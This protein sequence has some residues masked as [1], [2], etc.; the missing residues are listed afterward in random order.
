MEYVLQVLLVLG[1]VLLLWAGL[2]YVLSRYEEEFFEWIDRAQEWCK[3][4]KKRG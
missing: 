4:G 2:F 3:R 1:V